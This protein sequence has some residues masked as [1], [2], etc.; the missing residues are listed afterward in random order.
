MAYNNSLPFDPG[1]PLPVDTT[2]RDPGFEPLFGPDEVIA[3]L[4]AARQPS[5]LDRVAAGFAELPQFQP[6]RGTSDLE[7]FL[8]ALANSAARTWGQGRAGRMEGQDKER[9]LVNQESILRARARDAANIRAMERHREL[10]DRSAQDQV[11][12]RKD[13]E[14]ERRAAEEWTRQHNIIERDIRTRPR[15]NQ[16]IAEDRRRTALEWSID[17]GLTDN[18]R[19]DPE[20]KNYIIIRDQYTTALDARRAK[21]SAGDIVLIRSLARASD[22]GST[23]R[24]EEYETFK[25]A[26]GKLKKLG[27]SLTTDMIGAGILDEATRD[28]ILKRVKALEERKRVQADRSIRRFKALAKKYGRDPDLIMNDY[29]YD[30]ATPAANPTDPEGIL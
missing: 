13:L 20:L 4:I 19:Q 9:Q 6:R 25:A 26:A 23:V 8:A 16:D 11:K 14:K 29:N 17:N 7:A 28:I 12:E 22:P 21:S 18:I 5:A 15:T 30:E 1:F 27:I 24:E 2:E 10:L 3:R